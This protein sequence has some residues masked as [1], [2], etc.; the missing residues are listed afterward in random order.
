VRA[1]ERASLPVA[2][3]FDHPPPLG[4]LPTIRTDEPSIGTRHPPTC[5]HPPTPTHTTAPHPSLS[6][7]PRPFVRSYFIHPPHPFLLRRLLRRAWFCIRTALSAHGHRGFSAKGRSTR[8]SSVV[9]SRR[10]SDRKTVEPNPSV[11][12]QSR[13]AHHAFADSAFEQVISETEPVARTCIARGILGGTHPATG[14]STGTD[15]PRPRGIGLSGLVHR[16]AQWSLFHGGCAALRC[17]STSFHYSP[18][19]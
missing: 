13:R 2:R 8:I 18:S 6:F 15:I 7:H 14:E 5:I 9:R 4:P 12:R 10:H 1:S 16:I 19:L 11:K 17:H 3:G